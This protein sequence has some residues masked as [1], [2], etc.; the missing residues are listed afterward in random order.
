MAL[1]VLAFGTMTVSAGMIAVTD[2]ITLRA[3]VNVPT[4]GFSTAT[5]D[6]PYGLQVAG[7]DLALV[8]F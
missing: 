3:M 4:K 2:I 7:E 8:F 1:L 6:I 5:L